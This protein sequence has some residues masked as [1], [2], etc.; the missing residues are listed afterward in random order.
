MYPS[1]APMAFHFITDDRDIDQRPI[2][3]SGNASDKP[4]SDRFEVRL[5]QCRRDLPIL[6]DNEERSH[7]GLPAP[8]GDLITSGC[9]ERDR[10]KLQM[11][12]WNLLKEIQREKERYEY[13]TRFEA[14][15]H[16]HTSAAFMSDTH[17]EGK[18]LDEL[19]DHVYLLYWGKRAVSPSGSTSLR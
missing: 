18:A 10:S 13:G 9:L 4:R 15:P 5:A 12:L 7:R 1:I 16:S 17:P 19:Y 2:L 14:C 11:S 8:N 6:R 3:S